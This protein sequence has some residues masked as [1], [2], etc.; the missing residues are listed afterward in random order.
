MKKLFFLVACVAL[1]ARADQ[2]TKTL[3]VYWVDSE[4]GGSTLIVTPA[5]ESVLIDTGN[6]GARDLQDLVV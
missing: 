5:G 1:A 6:P 2:K 3:D 4:G